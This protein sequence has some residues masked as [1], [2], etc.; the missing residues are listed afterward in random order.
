MR[1]SW[2]FRHAPE[3]QMRVKFWCELLW[4]CLARLCAAVCVA[5]RLALSPPGLRLRGHPRAAVLVRVSAAFDASIFDKEDVHVVVV[6]LLHSAAVA[7][8]NFQ[9]ANKVWRLFSFL[10]AF[11]VLGTSMQ[12]L[13][14]W[15][16]VGE[17][18]FNK[19]YFCE[20]HARSCQRLFFLKWF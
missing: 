6:V 7:V 13:H 2:S 14:S 5:S 10:K 9:K 20:F 4:W 18:F 15:Y 17:W 19:L 12:L 1:E 11:H 16:T 3:A 8:V